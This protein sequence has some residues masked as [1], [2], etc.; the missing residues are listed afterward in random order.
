MINTLCT[1]D[2][3]KQ[4]LNIS[5]IL[6]LPSYF[7]SASLILLEAI[8][9]NCKILTSNNVGM[10]YIIPT[11]YVCNDVYDLNDWVR[12]IYLLK[13]QHSIIYNFPTHISDIT[14]QDSFNEHFDIKTLL[15]NFI[16][17]NNIN[18]YIKRNFEQVI[19]NEEKKKCVSYNVDKNYVP[20]F[21]KDMKKNYKY[22]YI[23]FCTNLYLNR[24]QKNIYNSF[25]KHYINSSNY[26]Y[27]YYL[28]SMSEKNDFIYIRTNNCYILNYLKNIQSLVIR[29]YINNKYILQLISKK[30]NNKIWY[31]CESFQYNKN[32][33]NLNVVKYID[34]NYISLKY[35][36]FFQFFDKVI[37]GS[38]IISNYM[39][40]YFSTNKYK[41]INKI[42][43]VQNECISSYKYDIIYTSGFNGSTKSINFFYNFMKYLKNTNQTLKICLV[44]KDNYTNKL[45]K[46]SDIESIGYEH[47][48]IYIKH[49]NVLKFYNL[50]KCHLITSNK[51]SQPRTICESISQNCFN[52]ALDTLTE[53]LHLV[54]G[55]YGKVIKTI[56]KVYDNS[57]KVYKYQE[58]ENDYIMFNE[59]IETVNNIK[60]KI[61]MSVF[62]KELFNENIKN[63]I[64]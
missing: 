1:N 37:L 39:N 51:D 19:Y 17:N 4:Y 44:N 34:R 48:D 16:G 55:K 43:D 5:E 47:L 6:I 31:P 7:E 42:Y 64:I 29:G 15:D 9:Q 52:I 26:T 22:V 38:P 24:K 20:V 13:K 11:K 45:I 54:K 25:E 10:S 57:Y 23:D 33:E 27:F 14:Y 50:S 36:K 61:N 18:V 49:D 30:I 46:I 60:E 62:Q 8:E 28:K 32:N 21:F 41:Y 63:N 53:G 40:K 56:N 3:V 35:D 12:K 2:K 59:I 58:H